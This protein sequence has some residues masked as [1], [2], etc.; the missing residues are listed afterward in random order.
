MTVHPVYPGRIGRVELA[1]EKLQY[2]ILVT[3]AMAH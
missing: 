3:H 1:V 2:Q